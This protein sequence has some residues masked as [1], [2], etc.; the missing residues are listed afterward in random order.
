V[1]APLKWL[2]K[3]VC[4][5]NFETAFVIDL[6]AALKRLR[7]DTLKRPTG[8]RTIEMLDR[9]EA[10]QD[11]LDRKVVNNRAEL[12]RLYGISRARVTQLMALL[13][14]PQEFRDELRRRAAAGQR[15]PSERALRKDAD[16]RVS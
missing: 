15:V 9:A 16:R 12:A 10:F 8:P 1:K 7:P 5:Q 13:R 6:T 14:F 2:P 3:R 11:L 4:N